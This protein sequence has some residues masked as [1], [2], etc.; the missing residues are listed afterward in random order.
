MPK[1][2][3]P[4]GTRITRVHENADSNPDAMVIAVRN[5]ATDGVRRDVHINADAD[6]PAAERMSSVNTPPRR[7]SSS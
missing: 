6:N 4:R 5:D 2:S 1:R 3:E 7:S